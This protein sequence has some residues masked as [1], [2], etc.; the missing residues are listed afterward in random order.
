MKLFLLALS[1]GLR[2]FAFLILPIAFFVLRTRKDPR[3]KNKLDKF[4]GP[5]Q[6]VSSA[7]W[8]VLLIHW[9]RFSCVIQLANH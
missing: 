5:M 9:Q 6:Q 3:I 7:H 8:H 1:F 2:V 4:N